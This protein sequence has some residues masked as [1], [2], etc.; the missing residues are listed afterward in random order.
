[1]KPTH[2]LVVGASG[3]IGRHAVEKARAAGYRVRALVRDPSRIHFGC[4]VEVVQGDLTSVESMRQALDG[5]DGIVFTHGSNGGPTLTETVDYGAVRNA[6]EALDGRPARIA[7][8]TSIGVTN[9]DN[10]Y[11]RSTEA[12][13]WKRHSERLVRASGNEYTIVRP[14]WF[15]MEGAD[16]HQLKFEQ[17]DRRDPMGPRRS[18]TH[19]AARK[20]TIRRSNSSTWPARR[21]PTPNSRRCSPHCNPTPDSTACWTATTSPSAPSPSAYASRSHASRRC[22]PNSE[23][24][25]SKHVPQHTSPH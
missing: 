9:M 15:D 25:R 12:H 13:D 23:R 8:M 10:D 7:L 3:S 14:G 21:K 5:I 1:M 11:N 4:G 2:V 17:G 22:A 19:S 16:E 20:R 6:L 18:S 24:P